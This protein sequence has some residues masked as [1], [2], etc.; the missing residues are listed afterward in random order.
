VG[1]VSGDNVEVVRR[2]MTAF[3][4][5][6]LDETLALMDANV[7]FFAPQTALSVA[8][9]ATYHGHEGIRQYFDDVAAVW[10]NLEVIPQ[11]FRRGEAH[12]VAVGRIAGERSGERIDDEVAWA[13]KLR[14]GRVVW[15]R[16]YQE[17]REALTDVGIE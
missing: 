13:W 11:D 16:V 17:P 7:E 12:V 3:N 10:S 1:D 14:D 8:R 5:R 15:G 9:P 4:E 2:L 6:D